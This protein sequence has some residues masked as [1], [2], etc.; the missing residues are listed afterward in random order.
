[1]AKIGHSSKVSTLEEFVVEAFA[2]AGL[3]WRD[4]VVT[5]PS[6]LRPSE[7]MVSRA[8]PRKAIQKLGWSAEFKMRDVIR[9]MI[10]NQLQGSA[11]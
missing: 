5:D 9:M 7:I 1:L 10:D 4:H 3:D 6:L 11:R 2:C 8:N